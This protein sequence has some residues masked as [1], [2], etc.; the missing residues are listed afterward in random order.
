MRKV[1]TF[2]FLV[3]VINFIELSR[4]F[5][6]DVSEDKINLNT[7]E[8][9]EIFINIRSE[10]DDRIILYPKG[11]TTWMTI[12]DVGPIKANENKTIKFILS[13]F[14]DS[15]PGTYKVTLLFSSFKT[16]ES[17]EKTLFITLLKE[18]NLII[19]EVSISSDFKAGSNLYVNIKI[20]NPGIKDVE[21]VL[22]HSRIISEQRNV[23][24]EF[25]DIIDIKINETKKIEKIIKIKEDLPPGKY[26]LEVLLLQ[27]GNV[28]E[29]KAEEFFIKAQ[30]K[31]EKT[32]LTKRFLL[33]EKV[34]IYIKNVGN[35]VAYNETFSINLHPISLLS[36]KHISGP[37][38]IF[39]N[40][41]CVW[42]FPVIKVG[43]EIIIE[44]KLDYTYISIVI[45]LILLA[46]FYYFYKLRSIVIRKT[47]LKRKDN[48][49]DIAIEVKNNTGKDVE[50]VVIIDRI[51]IIIFKI[52][53]FLGP[54]PI[55]KSSER[56]YELKW[57]I[58]KLKKGEERIISYKV[59]E[60]IKVEGKL[61]LPGP[62]V[63]YSISNKT[64]TK[65]AGKLDVNL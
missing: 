27:K 39:Y 8:L 53:Q 6:V 29:K 63:T 20:F 3:L 17:K 13:P 58:G 1:L 47:I 24:D 40:Y 22:I 18:T 45:I 9:K 55:I 50:K 12:E 35:A 7:G 64:F 49:I 16:G 34:I 54:K 26:Y 61:S 33:E 31:I 30:P 62:E 38:P 37:K 42:T 51:P 23:I 28:I 46:V 2:L 15:I 60:I 56:Y 4:A 43:E 36:Y 19:K 21:N 41:T 11:L 65:R 48:L 44:Y 32:I 14:S 57:K 59:Q 25:F 52:K 10:I 5:E